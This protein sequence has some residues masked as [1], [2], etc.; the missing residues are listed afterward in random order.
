MNRLFRLGQL[1]VRGAV[2]LDE[3][4]R[5]PT[6][7]LEGLDAWTAYAEDEVKKANKSAKK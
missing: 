3:L 6:W 7:A 1:R 4:T 5:M 2:T